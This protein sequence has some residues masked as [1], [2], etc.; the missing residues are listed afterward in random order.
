M[1]EFVEYPWSHVLIF[2]SLSSIFTMWCHC[3]RE[4]RSSEH[5]TP[6]QSGLCIGLQNRLHRFDS[7]R[8]VKPR[9]RDGGAGEL[10]LGLGNE[11]TR[12]P[13]SVGRAIEYLTRLEVDWH[14]R[15]HRLE[16]GCP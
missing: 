3:R 12:T 15:R 14:G 2:L 16:S 1:D 7:G 8:R 11:K 6:W 4:A 5:P 10:D 9:E 13:L